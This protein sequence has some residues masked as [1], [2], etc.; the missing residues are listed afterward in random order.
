MI[1][2]QALKLILAISVNENREVHQIDIST[3]FLYGDLD[4]EVYLAIPEGF[5]QFVTGEK[6]EE[7]PTQVLKL[8]K[9]LYGLKQSP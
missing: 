3:A 4:E 2:Q 6:N 7:N 1:K 5:N 9:A 8:N